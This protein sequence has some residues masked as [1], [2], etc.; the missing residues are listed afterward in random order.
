M[1]GRNERIALAFQKFGSSEH[2]YG[3]SQRDARMHNRGIKALAV[4]RTSDHRKTIAR[5]WPES[6]R[7]KI[8]LHMFRADDRVLHFLIKRGSRAARIIGG[9][10]A[11]EIGSRHQPPLGSLPY[12]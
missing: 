10:T 3:G 8:H 5:R 6:N 7:V 11:G 12:M 1:I 4:L 2:P 9:I